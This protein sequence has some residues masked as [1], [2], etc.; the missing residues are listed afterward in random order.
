[1]FGARQRRSMQAAHL[2]KRG[3][4]VAGFAEVCGQSDSPIPETR[5]HQ[6]GRRWCPAFNIPIYRGQRCIPPGGV[7]S[8]SQMSNLL[9]RRAWP[10]GRVTARDV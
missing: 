3:V 6:R 8:R 4:P 5:N 7:A 10:A 9:P 1:M 2:A